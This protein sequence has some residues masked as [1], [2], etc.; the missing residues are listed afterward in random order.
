MTARTRAVARGPPEPASTRLLLTR[1]PGGW[2]GPS[3]YGG[4]GEFADCRNPTAGTVRS[5]GGQVEPDHPARPSPVTA[6][7]LN[8]PDNGLAG[9]A[10]RRRPMTTDPRTDLEIV[11]LTPATFDALA[12]LFG[13][14]GEPRWCWCAFWRVRGAAG[15]KAEAE[16]N[17]AWL[18][19]LAEQGEAGDPAPG[20]VALRNGRAVGWVSVG[21][22][23]SYP[24]LVHSTVLAPLDDRP[25]WSIVCFVV[26]RAERGHGVGTT[27]L[28][29]AVAHARRHGA[30]TL[31]AYPVDTGGGRVP[32]GSA[33]TGTV[34]MFERA[35]FEVA[36]IRRAT[37]TSRPRPI[38]RWE[39][40]PAPGGSGSGRLEGG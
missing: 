5:G 26:C 23:A 4:S 3:Q 24:R 39:L 17:R 13:E 37:P 33:N 12:D 34:T 35:G 32:A 20:L 16:Q 6:A 11:P 8:G 15:S 22:R 14:G 2:Y 38:V 7:V 36:A 30:A 1:L 28:A 9:P 31:E 10:T 27:L 21:P 19:G 18:L 29:A 25:V 40:G